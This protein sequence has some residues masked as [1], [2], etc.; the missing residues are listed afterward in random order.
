ML[1]EVRKT[2]FV[3]SKHHPAMLNLPEAAEIF[4]CEREKSSTAHECSSIKQEDMSRDVHS[5]P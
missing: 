5:V 3:V 4:L 1:V 2:K